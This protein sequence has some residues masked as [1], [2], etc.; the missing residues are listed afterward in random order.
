MAFMQRNNELN[1]AKLVKEYLARF[2]YVYKIHRDSIYYGEI[3]QWCESN[4]S[5]EFN[6]WFWWSPGKYDSEANLHI[7][8][9]RY[10]TMFMLV[11]GDKL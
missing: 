6:E 1:T 10:N 11:W 4:F 3:K 7:R 9:P 2:P 8:N 5:K